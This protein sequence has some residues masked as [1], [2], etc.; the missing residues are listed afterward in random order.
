MTTVA[1]WLHFIVPMS[2][3]GSP[4]LLA[5]FEAEFNDGHSGSRVGRHLGVV[6]DEGS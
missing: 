2:R 6:N 4:Y 3:E 1:T 5:Q